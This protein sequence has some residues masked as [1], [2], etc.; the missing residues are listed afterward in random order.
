[1]SKPV[2]GQV[3]EV[4]LAVGEKDFAP[5]EAK[6]IDLLSVQFTALWMDGTNTLSYLFYMDEGMT[7]RKVDG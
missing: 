6:V 1:M 2:E 7:W 5:K 4:N 3:I